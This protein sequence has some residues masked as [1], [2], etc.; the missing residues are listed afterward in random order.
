MFFSVYEVSRKE[1]VH[2]IGGWIAF[3]S[4]S[5]K[6]RL[7]YIFSYP[8][9]FFFRWFTIG[10]VDAENGN[11]ECSFCERFTNLR[12]YLFCHCQQFL[13]SQNMKPIITITYFLSLQIASGNWTVLRTYDTDADWTC[14]ANGSRPAHWDCR[15]NVVAEFPSWSFWIIQDRIV[16]A[17]KWYWWATN[18]FVS[19]DKNINLNLLF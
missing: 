9:K 6:C 4:S 10:N 5:R 17:Y 13:N 18:Q 7:W 8:A 2:R 3:F 1:W 14:D 12:I 11:V 15:T 19:E 16:F